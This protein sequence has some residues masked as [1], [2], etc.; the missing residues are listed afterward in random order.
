MDLI[1]TKERNIQKLTS[2]ILK[3]IET[4]HHLPPVVTYYG[5]VSVSAKHDDGI[6]LPHEVHF[7]VNGEKWY[8]I[9]GKV[10]KNLSAHAAKSIWEEMHK[11]ATEKLLKSSSYLMESRSSDIKKLNAYIRLGC[12]SEKELV[13][14]RLIYGSVSLLSKEV[15]LPHFSNNIQLLIN[16]KYRYSMMGKSVMD[17]IP[18]PAERIWTTIRFLAASE[19]EKQ[20]GHRINAA[21]FNRRFVQSYPRGDKQ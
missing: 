6:F 3:T 1:K 14:L 9:S 13:P 16:G 10:P 15:E 18:F 7:V 12:K 11:L 5:S 21:K 19:L 2:Y 20:G 8:S 4:N 17:Q